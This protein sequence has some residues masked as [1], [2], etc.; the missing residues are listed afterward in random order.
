MIL[1]CGEAL[2]DMLPR[3]TTLG[4][5]AFAPYAGGAIFNTAI[6]L[7][8]LGIDT[9]FFTGLSDDMLGDI[10]RDTLKSSGVDFSYEPGRQLLYDVSFH[11]GAGKTLAIVGGSGSGKSTL[12]R[13]LF[14]LYQPDAGTVRIDGQDLRY[15]T[16]Q[17]LR[18]AIGI[19]PQDTILFNDTLAYNIAYGR[20]GATRADV[21]K[22]ARSAQLTP[23][24]EALPD[25][26]ETRVGER[27]M[28]LSGGERQ[29]IAIARALLKSPPIIVFDEA[30]S[31]LDTRT[32]RAIQDEMMQLA[33][34][35][36]SLLIAHRLSTVVAADWILV[37]EHGRLVEQGC[38]DDLLALGGVYAQMWQLQEQERELEQ[39]EQQTIVSPAPV[40]AIPLSTKPQPQPGTTTAQHPSE[41][42]RL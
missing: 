19:V 32:E 8:R 7:G 5:R 11:V 39:I 25:A 18:D 17:S 16:Q 42:H 10:L 36:T 22:A 9:G 26:Y 30:T 6:A 33:E 37:M 20:P 35:R 40:S 41:P 21:V 15:V 38:H 14:R 3:E 12:A 27:G 2:I 24:I 29:R 28:R 31:A 34:Q 23:F 4:E 13:L 1:C